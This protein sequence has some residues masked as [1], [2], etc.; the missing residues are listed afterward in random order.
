MSKLTKYLSLFV[1]PMTILSVPAYAHHSNAPHFDTSTE[2]TKVGT[3]TD[4]KFVNPHAFLYFDVTEA[5]GSISSWRC[6]TDS[7]S[8]LRRRGYTENTFTVGESISVTGNPAKREDNHCFFRDFT[9]ADGTSVNRNTDLSTLE[10][11]QGDGSLA[12]VELPAAILQGGEADITGYWWDGDS[13]LPSGASPAP[14]P[15]GGMAMMGMGVNPDGSLPPRLQAMMDVGFTEAGQIAQ[16]SY[17]LIYD[18]PSLHCRISNIIDALGRDESVNII[19]QKGDRITI[20]YGYMDYL[21]TIYLDQD[22]HPENLTPTAGG[23]SIGRWE[24]GTLIVNTTG[25]TPSYLNPQI[26]VPTSSALEITERFTLDP[27]TG[28]LHRQFT[29]RDPI[30]WLNEYA[31]QDSYRPSPEPYSAYNC[32]P[33]SGLNN[34][35]PGTPEYEA[36]LAKIEAAKA[37]QTQIQGGSPLAPNGKNSWIKWLGILAGL[38]LLAVLFLSRNKGNNT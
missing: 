19:Q 23:H 31:G 9:F 13:P 27:V 8:G 34:L 28:E 29:A 33:L 17:E 12:P 21:R 20:L 37:N 32:E 22:T 16:D 14:Q 35:R 6:E 10:R 2:V 4:W 15:G 25:F 30:N 26:G 1:L 38:A 18:D 7:A 36:E 5:D 11:N 3:I 24:D